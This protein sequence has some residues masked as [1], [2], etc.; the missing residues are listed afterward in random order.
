M[1]ACGGLAHPDA[2]FERRRQ[3]N[4]DI[5]AGQPAPFA[6]GE[7]RGKGCGAGVENDAAEMGVVEIEHVSHLAVCHGRIQQAQSVT[8]TSKHCGHRCRAEVGECLEQHGYCWMTA[9]RQR[10]PDPVE[11][12]ALRFVDGCGREILVADLRQK[13]GESGCQS[14]TGWR[15]AVGVLLPARRCRGSP[16]HQQCEARAQYVT[17]TQLHVRLHCRRAAPSTRRMLA[18]TE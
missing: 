11:D 5:A 2:G 1:M 6:E 14:K 16:T 17:T 3:G 9:A 18:S 15:G 4:D 10:T 13:T 12:G 7:Q 8:A